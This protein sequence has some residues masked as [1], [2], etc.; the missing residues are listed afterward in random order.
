M[1][2]TFCPWVPKSYKLVYWIV[3]SFLRD[4]IDSFFTQRYPGAFYRPKYRARYLVWGWW[5]GRDSGRAT[6]IATR[7]SP[8]LYFRKTPGPGSEIVGLTRS[9]SGPVQK[10]RGFV[11]AGPGN[12]V[13]CRSLL[14]IREDIMSWN[15][16]RVIPQCLVEASKTE[17]SHNPIS[18]FKCS[19]WSK[20]RVMNP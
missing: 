2:I 6:R 14:A 19:N 17:K 18:I 12:P 13:R 16:Q 5:K 15:F 4:K 3:K 11:I 8:G 10:T 9:H 7:E 1:T 20:F